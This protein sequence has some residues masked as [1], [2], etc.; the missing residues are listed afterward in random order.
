MSQPN[1]YSPAGLIGMAN[2]QLMSLAEGGKASLLDSVSDL[3]LT[4]NEL[5][6]RFHGP[7][8]PVA[9]L[10]REAANGIDTLRRDIAD[11]DLGDLIADGRRLATE[12]PALAAGLAGALGFV[13][14]RL[15]KANMPPAQSR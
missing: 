4:V 11:R 7:A 10:L 1:T 9:G 14:V 3:V 5:A 13:A 6:G 12:Q 2:D 8:A 15:L